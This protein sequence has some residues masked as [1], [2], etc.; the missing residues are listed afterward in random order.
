MQATQWLYKLV[1]KAVPAM[2]AMRRRSLIAQVDGLLIGQR[3]NLTAVGRHIPG[4]ARE[5]DKIKRTDRLVGNVHLVTERVAVYGEIARSLVGGKRH[6]HILVDWSDVDTT[7][8]LFLLRAAV[9][10]GGR[11]LPLYEE[12]HARYHHAVDVGRFLERLAR[13]LP[14]PC[15][16]VLVTD[17][18]YRLPWFEAVAAMG[19]FYVGRVRNADYVCLATTSKWVP[20]KT[21]HAKATAHPRALGPLK[22]SRK[23]A[24]DTFAYLYHQPPKGRVKLNAYGK[25]RRNAASLKHADREREPWLLVSNLPPRHNLAHQVIECYRQRMAIEQSFRDLK[26]HRHGFAFRQNLGRNSARVANLLLIAALA[27]LA[28]WIIGMVGQ[29]RHLVHGLQANTERKRTVLS[30]FFIGTRLLHQRLVFADQEL[31]TAWRSLCASVKSH[32][33][34]PL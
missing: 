15:Q 19:W 32:E 10:I 18:G 11:A 6:P 7:K 33:P 30:V 20:N 28:T 16:P 29:Q 23:S 5:K 4:E 13:L 25:P 2:H 14:P 21:L 9:V 1:T 27:M 17:A 3:L 8:K 34:I 26:A 24:F 12:V 31:L 22:L